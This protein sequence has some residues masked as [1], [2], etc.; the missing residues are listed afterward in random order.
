MRR[1]F[2]WLSGAD[3]TILKDCTSLSNTEKIRF[4]GLGSL[5]LVPAVLGTFSMAYAVSTLTRHA[6]LYVLAGICWGVIVLLID[7]YLISTLHKSTVP[8][9]GGRTVPVVARLVFAVLVGIAVAHPLVLLWFD[10]SLV[11]T[12]DEN[13]R[14]KV[15]ERRAKADADV[16]AVPVPVASAKPLEDARIARVTRLDC[17]SQLKTYEQSNVRKQ[18][19]CGISS[20]EENCGP[21]CR[22]IQRK[23]DQVD[24]EIKA[25]DGRISLA[26]G[27]DQKTRKAYDDR[28]RDIRDQAAHDVADIN[29]RHSTD[30]L[31]RVAALDQLK[32]GSGHVLTVEWF[33]ICFFVFVD[34]LPMTMKITTPV[35]AYEHV[36][37]TRLLQV[38]ATE[39]ARQAAISTGR[40]E[41]A[42]ATANADAERV[43]GEMEVLTRVPVEVLAAREAQVAAFEQGVR[44]LRARSRNDSAVTEA[45]ILSIRGL[46]QEAF[47]R[48]MSR[49]EEFMRQR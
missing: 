42:I 39:R 14:S 40:T 41:Q 18:L 46:D 44:A 4:A 13:R 3:P 33:M 30:Y 32:R 19:P 7:R 15:E 23:F 20:G 31:A 12:I 45:E 26:K 29:A 49:T 43:L 11:Q 28:V 36:R 48:A 16:A 24:G 6:A 10:D 2:I 47:A 22:D 27:E 8:G 9:A 25:L 38:V 1:A 34:V 17:L 21:R 35:G 37:D 5:I